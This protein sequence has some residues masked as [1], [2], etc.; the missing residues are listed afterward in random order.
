MSQTGRRQL[1]VLDGDDGARLVGLVTMS[2][3]VRAHARAALGTSTQINQPAMRDVLF[4]DDAAQV[5]PA[6][7]AV[8]DVR[9][10]GDGDA[11]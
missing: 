11:V 10:G 9:V 4:D 3:V 5:E 1:A 2:D 6:R 8:E 7:D